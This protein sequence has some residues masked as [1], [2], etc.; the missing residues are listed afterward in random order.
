MDLGHVSEGGHQ[1]F[2]IFSIGLRGL[3]PALLLNGRYLVVGLLPVDAAE[4]GTVLFALLNRSP[5][6]LVLRGVPLVIDVPLLLRLE[7]LV[8]L[9]VYRFLV[10]DCF[11]SSFDTLHRSAAIAEDN[12]NDSLGSFSVFEVVF[13]GAEPVYLF[14]G[15]H[16]GQD[17]GS[18]VQD[19]LSAHFRML[20]HVFGN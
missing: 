7:L 11:L 3:L 14:L 5:R 20:L 4:D 9:I 19:Q 1:V 16:Y 18:S 17:R 6:L 15:A 13:D 8:L 10:R 2:S 12:A